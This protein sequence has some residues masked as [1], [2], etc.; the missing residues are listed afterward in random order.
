[1]D[2]L[3]GEGRRPLLFHSLSASFSFSFSF[4]STFCCPFI[5]LFPSLPLRRPSFPLPPSPFALDA[6]TVH[7]SYQ[8]PNRP[9][10]RCTRRAARDFLLSRLD[11]RPTGGGGGGGGGGCR[12]EEKGRKGRGER[13][14]TGRAREIW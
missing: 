8:G 2:Q 10:L 6:T 12:G 9:F 1:M 14:V 5:S 7:G 11:A 4:L 13:S 3:G